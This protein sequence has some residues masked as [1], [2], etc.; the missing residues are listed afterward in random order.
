[1][2]S[3]RKYDGIPGGFRRVRYEK[4][5]GHDGW[6]A[7][8]L[9]DRWHDGCFYPFQVLSVDFLQAVCRNDGGFQVLQTVYRWEDD[10]FLHFYAVGGRSRN[11]RFAM[12]ACPCFGGFAYRRNGV[13]GYFDRLLCIHINPCYLKKTEKQGNV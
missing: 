8:C 13:L 1:M 9:Y 2:S 4:L 5:L 12:A 11:D 10:C 3:A 6:Q 7:I